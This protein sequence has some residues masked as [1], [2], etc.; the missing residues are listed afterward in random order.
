MP[1]P[2][3][4]KCRIGIQRTARAAGLSETDAAVQAEHLRVIGPRIAVIGGGT[5]LSTLLRGLKEYTENIT[6]IVTV[7]DDG[8]GT[9]V[10]RQD[11]GMLA[12]GDIRNCVMALANTEPTMEKLLNY[13]FTDGYLKGQSF[14]N[15]FLA[16]LNGVYGSFDEA[17]RRMNEVLAVTGR[18]LPVTNENVYLYAA[19]EDGSTIRGESKI[20]AHKKAHD[21]RISHVWLEPENPPALQEAIEAIGS[22]ELIV[23]GPGSLY[24]SVIPNLLVDGIVDAVASSSAKKLYI[25]N[26]MTQ[27]GETE[28]Y[29]AFDH[30]AG[31]LSHAHGKRLFSDCIFNTEPVTEATMAHYKEEGAIPVEIDR[32]RFEAAG[33]RLYGFP[34]VRQIG[35]MVRHDPKKL[36]RAVM[37]VFMSMGP[38]DSVAEAYERIML[39][40]Q[41]F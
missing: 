14:G 34:L 10:L 19:F 27:D 23:L 7:A 24:T 5:G 25:M 40:T 38:R 21:C 17:V 26:I 20:Y 1:R 15:L 22:A 18:V 11:L 31:I 13:R 29:T 32:A 30:V 33:I 6:A 2:F 12:P 37:R 8:G 4:R 3:I 39:G 16:A 41:E 28:G 36:A 9:G 35:T